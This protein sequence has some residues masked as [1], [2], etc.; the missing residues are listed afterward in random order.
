MGRGKSEHKLIGDTEIDR[1]KL[2]PRETD[3]R[4]QGEEVITY[5]KE[6]N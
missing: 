6:R 3:Q 2:R 1:R 5:F 4:Q